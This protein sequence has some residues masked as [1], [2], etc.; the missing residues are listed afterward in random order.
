MRRIVLAL[1][2]MGLCATASMG[3]VFAPDV[4][5]N[6]N[7]VAHCDEFSALGAAYG[8]Y[9]GANVFSTVVSNTWT[10]NCPPVNSD[11]ALVVPFEFTSPLESAVVSYNSQLHGY[12]S[13]WGRCQ[14]HVVV[15]GVSTLIYQHDSPDY[16]AAAV[17]YNY[18]GVAPTGAG[19]CATSTDISDLIE[20]ATSFSLRFYAAQGWSGSQYN[21]GSF[22]SSAVAASDFSLVGN[23]VPEPATLSLIVL[24][25]LAIIR[26][27]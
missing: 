6:F 3:M 26:K 14:I 25:C 4:D 23:V 18:D 10:M 13:N 8:S 19:V 24:G 27:K 9:E 17:Y 5:G 16:G 21:G 12:G 1:V 2:V 7:L 22:M 11:A 15:D 20:G